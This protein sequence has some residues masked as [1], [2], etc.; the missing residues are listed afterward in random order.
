MM[1]TLSLIVISLTMVHSAASQALRGPTDISCHGT[2]PID[3]S[4]IIRDMDL[5]ILECVECRCLR[6]KVHCEYKDSECMKNPPTLLNQ[7]TGLYEDT[8]RSRMLR[9]N[10]YADDTK[11]SKPSRLPAAVSTTTS[12]T[13]TT[14][15]TT[16]APTTRELTIEEEDHITAEHLMKIYKIDKI[17]YV[18]EA[19]GDDYAAQW[20]RT[21]QKPPGEPDELFIEDQP[22][23]EPWDVEDTTTTEAPATLKT[24]TKTSPKPSPTVQPKASSTLTTAAPSPKTSSTISVPEFKWVSRLRASSMEDNRFATYGVNTSLIDWASI[25]NMLVLSCCAFAVY[26]L[27]TIV[28]VMIY[29]GLEVV[30]SKKHQRDAAANLA[31]HD[32][33]R[34]TPHY[35]RPFPGSAGFSVQPLK[36]NF[37]ANFNI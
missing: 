22:A 6:N 32:T 14:T 17:D 24:P 10:Q 20:Y 19:M 1:N 37:N 30:S 35:V 26:G 3:P 28:K 21:S 33:F 34:P 5:S 8:L 2:D 9:S 12:T 36:T 27:F 25:I 23:T 13:T 7:K 31:T 11:L 4:H 15:T 18:R 16:P 29:S